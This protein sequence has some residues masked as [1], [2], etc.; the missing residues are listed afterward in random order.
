MFHGKKIFFPIVALVRKWTTNQRVATTLRT[1]CKNILDFS[2]L[3][4][5]LLIDTKIV[6]FLYGLEQI[7]DI[8]AQLLEL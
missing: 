8:F 7:Y 1:T 6:V 2:G 4:L 3:Y 5:D